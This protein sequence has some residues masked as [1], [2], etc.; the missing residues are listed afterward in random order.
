MAVAGAAIVVS[1]ALIVR[2]SGTAVEPG[3]GLLRRRASAPAAL[4]EPSA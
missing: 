3:R 4:S 2:A 1:V